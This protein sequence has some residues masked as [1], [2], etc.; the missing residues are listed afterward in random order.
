MGQAFAVKGNLIAIA[1]PSFGNNELEYFNYIINGNNGKS[2]HGAIV[3]YSSYQ[4]STYTSRLRMGVD[5]TQ[6]FGREITFTDN[7]DLLVWCKD[8]ASVYLYTQSDEPGVYNETPQRIQASDQEPSDGFGLSFAIDGNIM[9]IGTYKVTS[10]K[11]Y[12]FT[13]ADGTWKEFLAIEAPLGSRYFGQSVS[14]SEK[15]V[16][17]SSSHNAYSYTL[18]EC[19]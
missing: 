19:T 14:L 13:L 1:D 11:V 17:V 18:G 15:T 12:L 9:A 6:R 3:I 4:S 10:G 5:C 7:G 2:E 16:I 8:P